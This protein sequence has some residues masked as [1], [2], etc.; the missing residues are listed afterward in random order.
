LSVNSSEKY[1]K[2]RVFGPKKLRKS[3]FACTKRFLDLLKKYF[4]KT[5]CGF[6]GHQIKSHLPSSEVSR[7]DDFEPTIRCKSIGFLSEH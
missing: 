2:L 1:G 3:I 5:V 4:T 6:Q 7:N